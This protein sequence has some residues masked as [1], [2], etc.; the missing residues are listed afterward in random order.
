MAV[1]A[2]EAVRE[3]A[4]AV[5]FTV[6]GAGGWRTWTNRQRQTVGGSAAEHVAPR[7]P[8]VFLEWINANLLVGFDHHCSSGL[9][10][11]FPGCPCLVLRKT[12]AFAWTAVPRGNPILRK[13]RNMDRIPA[14]VA[15]LA[16]P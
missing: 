3:G 2:G 8:R 12:E 1:Q 14:L 7:A 9:R 6:F 11:G 10:V 13:A 4:L 15:I 5:Y 16:P